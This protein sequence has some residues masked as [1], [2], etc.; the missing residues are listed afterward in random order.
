VFISERFNLKDASTLCGA[1]AAVSDRIGIATAAEPHARQ[2]RKGSPVS[3]RGAA[4]PGVRRGG[5][6]G[7]RGLRR[8]TSDG[9]ASR[10]PRRRANRELQ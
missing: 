5:S 3:R 10:A 1:A 2:S 7:E 4:A 8:A 9:G 6:G